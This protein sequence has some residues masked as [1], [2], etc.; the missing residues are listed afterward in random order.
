MIKMT[1]Y[2]LKINTLKVKNIDLVKNTFKM[3]ISTKENM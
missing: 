1:I 3:E 2:F